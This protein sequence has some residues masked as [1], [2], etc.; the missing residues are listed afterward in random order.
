[1]DAFCIALFWQFYT[2]LYEEVLQLM[3]AE[4]RELVAILKNH[5]LIIISVWI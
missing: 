3:A 1:M 2:P 5:Y 4:P